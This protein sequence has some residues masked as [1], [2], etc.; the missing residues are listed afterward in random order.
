L[1][2]WKKERKKERK[3][4]DLLPKDRMI[5]DDYRCNFVGNGR[6]E[7]K[8]KIHISRVPT[9]FTEEI[10]KRILTETLG[11]DAVDKVELVIPRPEEVE[12]DGNIQEDQ[13]KEERMTHRG[14]GFVSLTSAEA[15]E[16]ALKLPTI[17]GGRKTTSSKLHTMYLKPYAQTEEDKNSCYLWSLYRCPYGDDCKFM[18]KGPGGCKEMNTFVLDDAARAEKKKGKCFSFKK[19]K[20]TK[21]DAC[22]FSHDFEPE[23]KSVEF[24]KKE[25]SEKDC[26]NWKTKGKCKKRDN[27][28]YR[29]D[30]K[31]LKLA[32]KKLKKKRKENEGA[33]EKQPLSVRVFGMNYETT[34]EDIRN[35][36]SECGPIQDITFPIFE[37]SGRSK[38]Y[39]G[40]WFSSPKAVAKAVELDGQE[41]MG[42]WLRIQAG[43]MYLK[44][45]EELHQPPTKRIKN[46]SAE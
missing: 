2:V 43:K 7:N 37:D 25:N 20:C 8:F 28:P 16:T 34:E 21:G 29:H 5:D 42:R 6:D 11:D 39:C 40:V 44:Q 24:K 12:G 45:W 15:Q 33:K 4:E 46:T 19:G 18:H 1:F 14:F 41:L 22:P 35:F 13:K 30:E 38:G 10:V 17:K 36:F 9:K 32:L 31:V 3:K 23:K 27:C 26:I